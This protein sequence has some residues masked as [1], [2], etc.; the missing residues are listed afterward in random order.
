M[1]STPI[2]GPQTMEELENLT[3]VKTP[4]LVGTATDNF[5]H[6]DTQN[7]TRV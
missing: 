6:I 3:E 7:E 2:C 5:K 1:V 4:S